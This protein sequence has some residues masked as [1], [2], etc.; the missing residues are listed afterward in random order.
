MAPVADPDA[1]PVRRRS[2]GFGPVLAVLAVV[3]VGGL[4]VFTWVAALAWA[5]IRLVELVAVAF[6]SGWVCWRLG[7]RHG[8]RHPR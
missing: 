3:A 4:L 8:R 1:S 6:V 2:V 5:V 7:V